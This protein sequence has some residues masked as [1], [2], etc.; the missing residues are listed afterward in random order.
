[1]DRNEVSEILLFFEKLIKKILSFKPIDYDPYNSSMSKKFLF[2]VV[3]DEEIKAWLKED[4][5]VNWKETFLEVSCSIKKMILKNEKMDYSFLI[6]QFEKIND[7]FYEEVV[8]IIESMKFL[9]I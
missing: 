3:T 7:K 5:C 4:K 6:K 2:S 1:M 9:K 8:P